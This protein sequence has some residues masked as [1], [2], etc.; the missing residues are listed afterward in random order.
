M[1]QRVEQQNRT[2]DDPEDR[3]GEDQA[4]QGRGDDPVEG[5]VPGQQAD[6]CSEDENQRHGVLGRPAKADQQHTRQ[7]QRHEGQDGQ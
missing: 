1:F 6:H 2:E 7:H 4:L 5:H 3:R